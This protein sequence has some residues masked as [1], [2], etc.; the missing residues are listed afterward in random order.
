MHT[1]TY[2]YTVQHYVYG[3]VTSVCPHV[4]THMV[5]LGVDGVHLS[6][7]R[8]VCVMNL[9]TDPH[10][11]FDD[12]GCR[13]LSSGDLSDNLSVDPLSR[14]SKIKLFAVPNDW[15]EVKTWS[16]CKRERKRERAMLTQLRGSFFFS[17]LI[18]PAVRWRAPMHRRG[19]GTFD[20]VSILCVCHHVYDFHAR[21]TRLT[22]SGPAVAPPCAL[23][24]SG[25]LGI[26]KIGEYQSFDR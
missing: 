4:Y 10:F 11:I 23:P 13:L 7:G 17:S 18:F 1:A 9:I 15:A 26:S 22:N 25:N 14:S 21:H 3:R 12:V 2:L 19:V 16:V 6:T 8:P 24:G 5:L 20:Y